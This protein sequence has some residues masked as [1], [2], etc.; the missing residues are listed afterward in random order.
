MEKLT[1]G[2]FTGSVETAYIYGWNDAVDNKGR[3]RLYKY[4]NDDTGSYESYR[5][6]YNTAMEQKR[7]E[8][9]LITAFSGTSTILQRVSTAYHHDE[10]RAYSEGWNDGVSNGGKA[11]MFRYIKDQRILGFYDLG[12]KDAMDLMFLG[13]WTCLW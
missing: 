12:Y 13:I 10:A 8:A 9:G 5:L 2:L 1:A 4:L 11:H 6:G 3:V 7:F